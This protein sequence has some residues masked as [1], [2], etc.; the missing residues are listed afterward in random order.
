MYTVSKKEGGREENYKINNL[1][2]FIIY[3]YAGVR[4][5]E[6]GTRGVC[7]SPHLDVE[8]IILKILASIFVQNK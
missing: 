4:N 8:E 2:Y 5:E 1:T 6:T 3:R 7:P